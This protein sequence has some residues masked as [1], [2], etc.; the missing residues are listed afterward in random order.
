VPGR[1][2]DG[3]VVAGPAVVEADDHAVPL[4][5][6]PNSSPPAPDPRSRP[7]CRG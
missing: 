2:E 5:H 3:R 4:A 7:S 1:V 6:A